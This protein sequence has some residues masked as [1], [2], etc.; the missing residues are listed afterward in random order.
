M[1]PVIRGAGGV[2]GGGGASSTPTEAPNTLR[3]TALAEVLAVIGEGPI[4]EPDDLLASIYLNDVPIKSSD[5]TIN[6]KNVAATLSLGYPDQAYVPGSSAAEAAIL[7]GTRVQKATAIVRAVTDT[8]ATS[9]RVAMTIPSLVSVDSTSGNRSGSWVSIAI[10]VQPNGGSYTTV[11]SD[12]VSGKCISPV[13]LD[14]D[15]RLPGTGPWNIRFRRLNDDST[16]SNLSNDTYWSSYSVLRDYR[17]AY[18]DTVVLRLRIDA[19]QFNGSFPTVAYQGKLLILEVPSNYDPAARTYSGIWDGTFQAAHSDNPAWVLWALCTNDRWG[20]GRWIDATAVD[21]WSLYAAAQWFD[22]MVADGHGGLE[23]RF[24]F[25]G[26]IDSVIDAYRAIVTIAGACQAMAYWSSGA[27]HFVVDRATDPVKQLGPANVVEGRFVYQGSDLATRPTAVHVTWRDPANNYDRAV[28]PVEDPDL[29]ALHGL[30][31]KEVAALLCTSQ[32]QAARVGRYEL[33][34]AWA[35]TQTVQFAAGEDCHDLV[36]GDLVDVADPAIQ[37]RRMAGR[38]I[39]ASGTAVTLDAAVTIEPGQSYELRVVDQ[40]GALQSRAVVATPGDWSALTVASAFSPA[41]ITG[42]VW[43]LLTSNLVPRRFRVLSVEEQDGTYAVTAVLHDPNKQ[44]RIEG[45]AVLSLPAITA[46]K[47]GPID[48]PTDLTAAE[49][50]ERLPSGTY[51]HRVTLGWARHTD[52]RVVRYEVQYR[53]AADASY[54]DAGTA[55]G[56][57]AELDELGS[58]SFLL[59]VRAVAYDGSWSPWSDDLSTSLVGLY[60]PPPAVTD[61]TISVIGDTALLAWSAVTVANLDHY[62][63]RYSADLLANWQSMV[64]IAPRVSGT[65][66]QTAARSGLYAVKAITAQ[67]VESAAAAFVTSNVS[68][69]SINIVETLVGNPDWIGTLGN[70]VIDTDRL[71]LRL[72]PSTDLLLGVGLYDET[73]FYVPADFYHLP[74]LFDEPDLF[75]YQVETSGTFTW[76]GSLDLVDL[77]TSRVTAALVVVGERIADDIW[78]EP[79]LWTLATIWGADPVGWDAWIEV[80]TT[81]DDPAGSPTWSAWRRLVASDIRFRGLQARVRLTTTDTAVTPIVKEASVIVD[82]PDRIDA[83]GGIAVSAAGTR[84]AFTSAFRG[85]ARPSVVIT[86]IEGAAPGD[87]ADVTGV[88]PAGFDITV[89]NGTTPQSGRHVDYH[90]KGYGQVITP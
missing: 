44:A 13:Q 82:M 22:E 35:E 52:P 30:R 19:E 79:D 64:Q 85:P 42:A 5:G 81:D 4:P 56:T 9:A 71:A 18:P 41:P 59:R 24:A 77:Y 73:D 83:Q 29:I 6:F 84:V 54:I 40:S 90:A 60:A 10:D 51:R 23:P 49:A 89:K 31:I 3:S 34:T 67:T 80:R 7:V 38:L 14:Y 74:D 75:G 66:V 39:D 76:P 33:E 21:K 88:D 47:T 62:E 2:F 1:R 25:N 15:V 58:G 61:F 57:T 72:S 20:L 36:P 68:G 78:A 12:T 26:V 86:G 11:V 87:W 53:A 65:S 17:L 27:A 70:L 37:S 45:G 43:V 32:G 46:W 48:R 16:S 50:I 55:Y 69:L 8:S 28:E 63:V